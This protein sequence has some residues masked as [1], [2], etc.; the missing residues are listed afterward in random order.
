MDG[1]GSWDDS[2]FILSREWS[3]L[4]SPCPCST[5]ALISKVGPGECTITGVILPEDTL[6]IHSCPKRSFSGNSFMGRCCLVPHHPQASVNMSGSKLWLPPQAR[7]GP[8]KKWG[9]KP[10]LISVLTKHCLN[11]VWSVGVTDQMVLKDF[12][13]LVGFWFCVFFY[14]YF[15][16]FQSDQG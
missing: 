12:V 6:S 14:C 4:K 13:C 5:S 16:L 11:R 2:V 7:G 15:G 8:H 1:L 10:P 3:S 9:W